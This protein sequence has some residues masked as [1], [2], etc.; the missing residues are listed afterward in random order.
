S[1]YPGI[2]YIMTGYSAKYIY[3]STYARFR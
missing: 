3:S 1:H 2:R